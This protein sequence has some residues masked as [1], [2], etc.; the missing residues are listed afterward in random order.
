MTMVIENHNRP[1]GGMGFGPLYQNNMHQHGH[2]PQFS[3]PWAQH[4]AAPS[5]P[6]AYATPAMASNHVGPKPSNA[7]QQRPTTTLPYSSIP[8]S[9]PSVVASNNYVSGSYAGSGVVSVPQDGPRSTLDGPPAY[10]AAAPVGSFPAGN[11]NPLGF[12]QSLQP[13]DARRFSQT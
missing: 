1:Y 3:N 9:A 2:P 8:V 6:P 4:T 5:N 12:P 11:Y 7:P 10:T 13:P